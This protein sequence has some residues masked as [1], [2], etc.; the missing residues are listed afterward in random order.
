MIQKNTHMIL[1]SF[2]LTL[3]IQFMCLKHFEYLRSPS[4]L[5]NDNQFAFNIRSFHVTIIAQ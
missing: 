5:T 2:I 4:V 1:T 3:E